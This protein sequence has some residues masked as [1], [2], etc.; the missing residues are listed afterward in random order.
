MLASLTRI[1][2]RVVRLGL[3]ALALASVVLACGSARAAPVSFGDDTPSTIRVAGVNPAVPQ[4]LNLGIGKSIVVE[5]P[6][7]AKEVFV[8]NP[9]V[10][11]A[12][13]RSTRKVFLIAMSDGATSVFIMDAQGAQIANLE[14]LVGRDMNKLRRT[15]KIA[16][17]GSAITV[18][19]VD[20]T[21]ILTGEVASALDA[22]QAA[23]I[24][25]G[26]IGHLDGGAKDT[27]G[28]VINSLTVRAKDQV[29][30]KVT[31]AEISREIIK[32]LGMDITGTN[33]RV[34]KS[35]TD[36]LLNFPATNSTS[37]PVS[38]TNI[39]IIGSAGKAKTEAS[40]KALEKDGV[41]HILAEPT[42]TAI[43][44]EAS[45]FTAGGT[46][47]VPT[48]ETCT[49]AGGTPPCTVGVDFKP[50]G[51]TLG[52]TPVVLSP[53]RISLRLTT[54][55]TDI[56]FENTFTFVNITVPGTKTRQAESTVELPSGGAVALAG[57]IQQE[58]V[59]H[60]NGLPGL[61]KLPILGALF[62][63]QD[64]QRNETDL[65]IIV[66]PY[67]VKPVAPS[68]I[69]RPDDNFVDPTDPQ[70][71]LLGK[72]NKIYGVAGANSPPPNYRGSVG[73]IHD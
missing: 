43:S 61:M 5:L 15:L 63:S 35:P 32:Q 16:M 62:R 22:Q 71:L 55:V 1:A 18:T 2:I 21:V 3:P 27:T 51:V 29:M 70:T 49:G 57:L 48:N 8:A 14:I 12:V 19:A 68:D 72:L 7:D 46:F 33:W 54:E 39:D 40:I 11:N 13:V 45:K 52:F 66:T 31:I 65:V 4:K 50:Y 24:A 60:L 59:K 20:N 58:V 37:Q 53:G 30:V 9:K 38:N 44:G 64:Y 69:A 25:K 34:F 36:F 47:P 56:D 42:L 6:R 41:A 28:D 73:F 26:F 67:I 23:D 10:A 17:P